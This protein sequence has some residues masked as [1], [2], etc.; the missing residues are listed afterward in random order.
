MLEYV[1]SLI[2]FYFLKKIYSNTSDV[3][4][5]SRNNIPD[6]MSIKVK[7]NASFVWYF[8]LPSLWSVW[9][10]LVWWHTTLVEL[11][12]IYLHGSISYPSYTSDHPS[13]KGKQPQIKEI[14][15]EPLTVNSRIGWHFDSFVGFYWHNFILICLF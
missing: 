8:I 11:S 15:A 4:Y 14:N 1:N 13:S 2:Y 6:F 9:A 10:T 3:C 5:F 12:L 7:R